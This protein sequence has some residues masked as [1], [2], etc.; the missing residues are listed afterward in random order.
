MVSL[1]ERSMQLAEPIMEPRESSAFVQQLP[2][3]LS[4]A[5]NLET[6][7]HAVLF[8]DNLVVAGEYLSAYIEGAVKR[9][10]PTCFVGLARRQ[11]ET[12]FDQVGIR[13]RELENCGYLKHLSIEDFCLKRGLFSND[14]MLQ[15]VEEFLG[16][17]RQSKSKGARFIIVGSSLKELMSAQSLVECEKSFG[18]LRQYPLSTICCYDSQPIVGQ[19]KPGL[20]LELLKSHSHCLFQGIGMPINQLLG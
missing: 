5:Q 15:S 17:M 20:F 9:H 2:F 4:Y 10:Q 11:Y 12:L 14:K 6:G 16:I 7:D 18:S 3:A 1:E 13:T 8:Y 19:P